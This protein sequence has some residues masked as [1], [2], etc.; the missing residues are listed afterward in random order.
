VADRLSVLRAVTCT[1]CARVLVCLF[2]W[3]GSAHQRADYCPPDSA[4]FPKRSN[5]KRPT[6]NDLGESE[7][8]RRFRFRGKKR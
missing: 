7:E 2:D 1:L 3:G 4:L 5:V 8:L 6:K